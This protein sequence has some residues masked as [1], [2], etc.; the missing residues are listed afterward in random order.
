ME[1]YVSDSKSY[2]NVCSIF[3]KRSDS[4]D[5]ESKSYLFEDRFVNN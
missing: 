4:T 2:A 3:Q 1:A 5:T